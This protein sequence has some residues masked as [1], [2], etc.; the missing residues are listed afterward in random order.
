MKDFRHIESWIFDLDNTL[1][2]A[3]CRLFD[4]MHVKM[5]EYVMRH[6]EVAGNILEH[7][8]PLWCHA[9]L[10]EEFLIWS[11][12]GLGDVVGINN[13]K[14]AVESF[15]H[16]QPHH[17][18]LRVGSRAIGEHQL[19]PW[20]FFQRCNQ[21][22]IA[23]HRPVVNVMHI[24]EKAFWRVV[25]FDHEPAQRRAVLVKKA[26]SACASPLRIRRQSAA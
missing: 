10:R 12:L 15:S 20:Q 5:G 19:A 25:V 23:C 9:M 22:R 14:N 26:T 18:A 7:G 24:V 1:Y 21:F 13:V 11:A 2:P 3:S 17:H 16:A 8:G 6:F 4:Q